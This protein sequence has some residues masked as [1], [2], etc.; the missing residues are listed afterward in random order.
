MKCPECDIALTFHRHDNLAVCHSCDYQS[1]GTGGVPRVSSLPGCDL[2]DWGRRSWKRKCERG[3]RIIRACGWI[4]TAMRERGS[5]GKALDAF[6][7][8]RRGFCWARR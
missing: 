1:G 7:E 4:P 6:R 2:A 5:H 3:F 8:G